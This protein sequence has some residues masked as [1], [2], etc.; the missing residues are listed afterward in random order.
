MCNEFMFLKGGTTTVSKTRSNTLGEGSPV[1]SAS[2]ERLSLR[3]SLVLSILPG[4]RDSDNSK[5]LQYFVK[6]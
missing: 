1:A 3:I 4:K 6:A 5:K 2:L